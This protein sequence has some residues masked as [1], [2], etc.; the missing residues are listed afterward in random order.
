MNCFASDIA[1]YPLAGALAAVAVVG[2]VTTVWEIK[3]EDTIRVRKR[4]DIFRGGEH[5]HIRRSK[6]KYNH[7]VRREALH[8]YDKKMEIIGIPQDEYHSG[9]N[10]LV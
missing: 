9:D 5:E 4:T 8:R 3:R 10:M 6:E 7:W 1:L 2:A